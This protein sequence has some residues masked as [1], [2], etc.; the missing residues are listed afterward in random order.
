MTGNPVVVWG[1]LLPESVI[2]SHYFGVL[3]AFVA[4][5]TLIYLALA[6]AKTLPKVYLTDLLTPDNTRSQNRSIYPDEPG[7]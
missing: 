1:V 7:T 2:H 4:L 6:V 5:N 3:A